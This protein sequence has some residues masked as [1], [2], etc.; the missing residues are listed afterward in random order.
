MRILYDHQIFFSQKFGGVSRY[1]YELIKNSKD[2]FGCDVSGIHYENEYI[3]TLPFYKEFPVK[4]QFRKKWDI[5]KYLNNKNSIR[6]IKQ[7]KY[8]IFHPTNYDSYFFKYI[9][10]F[11]QDVDSYG[12]IYKKISQLNNNAATIRGNCENKKIIENIIYQDK[13][14]PITENDQSTRKKDYILF[15]GQRNRYKNFNRF[16]EAVAPL[17]IRYNLRLVCT[18][19]SF[20]KEECTLLLRNKI[21]DRTICNFVSESELQDTYAKAL[22]FVFPSLYEGFGFPILEAFSTGCPV[23][24]SNTSCFSEIA[25]DAAV[26]FD[27]Y[28]VDD[29]RQTIEKVLLDSSLQ[30]VLIAR[31]FERLQYFSWEK[32][33]RQTYQL[34]HEALS[35]PIA[36]KIRLVITIHD[37]IYEFFPE[38]F[39][40][41]ERNETVFN[42]YIMM[43]NAD[44]IIAISNNT[45]MDILKLYPEIEEKKIEV[46]YHGTSFAVNERAL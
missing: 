19:Q 20:S 10:R 28:F 34:Y 41:E 38:Y 26:Y 42:K 30:T 46:I 2:L 22:L 9:E 25:R 12:G 14:I 36:H 24:L 29:M 6:K 43:L 39:S 4:F 16:I 27:P 15:T 1:F 31:G 13:K 7:K 45:K 18:G 23:V 32:T 44:K 37:M 3:K 11:P 5:I 40:D 21:D 17:L 33:V 8:D 35:L